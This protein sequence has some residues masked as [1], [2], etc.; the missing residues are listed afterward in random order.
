M[1][2]AAIQLDAQPIRSAVGMGFHTPDFAG[3][4]TAMHLPQQLP[5]AHASGAQTAG[6]S[7]LRPASA[8]S[9]GVDGLSARMQLLIRTEGSAS[10]VARRCG[11][12]EG[13]VRN[14]CHGRSDISRE[15]CVIIARA[16]GVSLRW[17]VAGEGSMRDVD[18]AD[19]AAIHPPASLTASIPSGDGAPP[20]EAD[21][22][23]STVDSGLLAAAYRV[24]QSY[25]GLVGG[26]LSPM[27]RADAL[28]QLYDV[29]GHADRPG[30]ADRMV[31]FHSALG[32]YFCSRKSLIG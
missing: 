7:R 20:T 6:P 22:H 23:A 17:L 28:A 21:A 27:Q 30:H 2:T 14:W 8:A 25:I 4:D 1:S 32:G 29:L 18:D 26:S 16:L 12:S 9:T 11:F 15:R 10:A 31:A 5:E 3:N 19:D 13:A 24:L